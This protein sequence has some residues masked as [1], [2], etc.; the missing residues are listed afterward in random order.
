MDTD[1]LAA[2]VEEAFERLDG[3]DKLEAAVERWIQV[4]DLI[5]LGNGTNDKVEQY[6]GRNTLLIPSALIPVYL[7]SGRD[8]E[9]MII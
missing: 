9:E 6:C 2:S 4:L 5:I 8:D 3:Y 1:V 7:A